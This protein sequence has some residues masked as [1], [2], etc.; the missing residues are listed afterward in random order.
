[1]TEYDPD[2][3]FNKLV[4]LMAVITGLFFSASILHRSSQGNTINYP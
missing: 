2:E 1:M 4:K 3:L